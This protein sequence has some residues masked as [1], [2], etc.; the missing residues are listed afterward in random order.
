MTGKA[1]LG[2]PLV[3]L[4]VLSVARNDS[5]LKYSECLSTAALT[6]DGKIIFFE[7]WQWMSGDKTRGKSE[8]EE[9]LNNM[10]LFNY[11]DL[12][13]LNQMI[14]KTIEYSYSGIYPERAVLFFKKYHSESNILERN[15]KG[16]VLVVENDGNLVATGSIVDNEIS[17]VFVEPKN[18]GMGLGSQ[19]MFELEKRAQKTGF[20]EVTLSVSIPAKKFYEKLQYEIL[21]DLK[22]DVG[23]G[24]YL[25][26][27]QGRKKIIS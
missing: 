27:W 3:A 9:V 21:E 8:I 19:I 16:A 17:G 6:A 10:R 12:A 14:H 2:C 1:V 25:K 13:Q 5:C 7:E 22:I 18:Q 26:Y 4:G 23:E 15:L 20:S 11:S 24:Q